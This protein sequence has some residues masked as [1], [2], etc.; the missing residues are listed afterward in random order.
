MNSFVV[1]VVLLA[2]LVHAVKNALVKVDGDRLVFVAVMSAVGGMVALSTTPFLPM[3]APE[4]W[5]IM[6]VALVFHLG[7]S[8]FLVLS[9]NH[10]DFSHVYPVARGSAPLIIA[11]LSLTVIGEELSYQNL[12]AISVIATGVASL[13]FTRG[14]QSLRNPTAMVSALCLGVSIAGYTF[15]DGIGARL[16]GNPHSYIA[17]VLAMEP[18]PFVAF[19]AWNRG[20]SAL[21]HV[22]RVWKKATV[23]GLMGLA[24][25]WMIVWA[26]TVAPIALVA[27]LRE[28]GI[29]FALLIGVV[30]LKEPLNL[31]R[32]TATFVTLV[33]LVMLK[34]NRS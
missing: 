16:S 27:A 22:K 31:S 33:G 17:W 15:A 5:P 4:S 2:A 34:L 24:T 7:S 26:M 28:A 3:P 29:V 14:A 18:I 9:Y 19:V 1:F 8:I 10:G 23:A 20:D 13:A 32:L 11:L 6:A 12:L 21:P 30:I 25:Y